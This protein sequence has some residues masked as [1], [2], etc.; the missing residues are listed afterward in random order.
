[1]HCPAV[2]PDWAATVPPLRVTVVVPGVAVTVPPQLFESS[3]P[4]AMVKPVGEVGKLSVRMTDVATVAV[5]LKIWIVSVAVP[6][7][8]ILAG[9][10]DLLT[11]SCALAA[12]GRNQRS[13]K[14]P[15]TWQIKR[16]W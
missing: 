7:G 10:K 11:S 9:L 8:G 2:P 6:A 3:P 4:D 5:L 13:N 14:A 16:K 12:E 1:M 15:K